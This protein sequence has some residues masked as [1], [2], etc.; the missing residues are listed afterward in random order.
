MLYTNRSYDGTVSTTVPSSRLIPQV[1]FSSFV[2]PEHTACDRDE[3][4]QIEQSQ[5]LR[6]EDVLEWREI[7]DKKL[8]D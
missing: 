4:Q 7:D 5:R 1:R 3:V 8:P 6:L 2:C